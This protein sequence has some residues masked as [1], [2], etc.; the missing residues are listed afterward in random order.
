MN[1]I[2]ISPRKKVARKVL[3][4]CIL[5]G[6]SL[7]CNLP[8][9]FAES[10]DVAQVEDLPQEP[11]PKPSADNQDESSSPALPESEPTDVS[12]EDTQIEIQPGVEPAIPNCNV[13]DSNAFNSIVDGDFNF[14]TQDQ[15]NNCHFESNNGF[16]LMIGGGKPTS[17]DEMKQ[18]FEASFGALPDSTWEA[19]DGHYLGLAYSSVSVTAQGISSSGHSMVIVIGSQPWSDTDALKAIFTKLA[20][21]AARQLNAQFQ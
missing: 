19:K 20:E 7:A 21:E 2:T 8:S 5:I 1:Q 9:L 6:A 16:R 15:L 11:T 17:I 3:F 18:F 12:I 10:G 13:L 14:I 4:I